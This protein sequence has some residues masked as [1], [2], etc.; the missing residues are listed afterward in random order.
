MVVTWAKTWWNA[1]GIDGG[2]AY[3]RGVIYYIYFSRWW[4]LKDFVMFTRILRE[5][6][7][8][9]EHIFQMG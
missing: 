7:Q 6:I 5:M 2:V 1:G 3:I 8:F 9:D 4:Q